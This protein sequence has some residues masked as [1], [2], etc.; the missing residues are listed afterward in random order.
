M[1]LLILTIFL[2]G[3]TKEL[4]PE[5]EIIVD[6]EGLNPEETKNFVGEASRTARSKFTWIHCD[7]Q[8]NQIIAGYAYK[9]KKNKR[10]FKN[11]CIQNQVQ[12]YYCDHNELKSKK[13]PCDY[14][15]KNGACVTAKPIKKG[16]PNWIEV[17][18]E[19]SALDLP[20]YI[21][22]V[23]EESCLLETNN[24]EY[25]IKN[26]GCQKIDNLFFKVNDISKTEQKC[27]I[28]FYDQT[29]PFCCDTDGNDYFNLGKIYTDAYANGKKDHCQTVASGKN[30][31]MEM[32]CKDNKYYYDQKECLKLGEDYVCEDGT[33][34][35]QDKTIVIL[36]DQKI[37]DLD[38]TQ[39]YS[40]IKNEGYKV[41]IEDK[42]WN[43]PEEVRNYLKNVYDSV[44][45]QL[46]GTILI[47]EIPYPHYAVDK[48]VISFWFYQDLDGIFLKENPK[49]PNAYSVHEGNTN[50]EIWVGILPFYKTTKETKKKLK[51]YFNKNHQYRTGKQQYGKGYIEIN[52]HVEE[53]KTLE[54]YEET[55]G[56]GYSG[57]YSPIISSLNYWDKI[58]FFFD[59]SIIGKA[60]KSEGYARL[61]KKDYLIWDMSSHGDAK[62][63]GEISKY[64]LIYNK[65][66]VP[67]AFIGGCESGKLDYTEPPILEE[68]IYHDNSQVL[69]TQGTTTFSGGMGTS[70]KGF[71]IDTILK[72]LTQGQSFGEAIITHINA[73]LKY[74]WSEN[75]FTHHGIIVLMGDPTLEFAIQDPSPIEEIKPDLW[76]KSI[77]IKEGGIEITYCNGG[78]LVAKNY[79]NKYT[80]QSEGKVIDT[81]ILEVLSLTPGECEIIEKTAAYFQEFNLGEE[82]L[83]TFITDS[84]KSVNELN[85][86]NN[87]LTRP[88]NYPLGIKPDLTVK[89]IIKKQGGID[90]TY[91]NIGNLIAKNHKNKYTLL[92]EGKVIDTFTIDIVNLAAGECEII[93]KTAAY[94]QKFDL[95]EKILIT[96]ITDLKK[97]VGELNENNN[98]LTK[99]FNY[100]LG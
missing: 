10:I 87:Y 98:A 48:E 17:N 57:P 53:V 12:D 9:G 3:C 49:F 74:P 5:E 51:N 72:G 45:P 21:T 2:V 7:D 1:F 91:C 67:F 22:G 60:P 85:E 6:E 47:G 97:S 69:V 39:F 58:N 73:P 25:D 79:K 29:I 62:S 78:N 4:S 95:G 71:Y 54:K 70:I 55:I 32:R 65:I 30:Y 16:E 96:F 66:N 86:K 24:E 100:P 90:I 26:K 80:L 31:L 19:V 64:W 88:F 94:F 28:T 93:E 50:S 46:V 35:V 23:G 36:I 84:E 75:E 43:T 68:L 18:E 20:F 14:G 82:I 63:F 42:T 52:E 59:N 11:G 40:D 44:T 13:I 33:C 27:L 56:Y 89:S 81:F 34:I 92:S 99:Q 37:A 77:I 76:T 8:G 83:I 15:C 38:L 61:S 41:I